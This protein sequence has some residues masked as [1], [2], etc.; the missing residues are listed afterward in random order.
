MDTDYIYKIRTQFRYLT[1]NSTGVV[2]DLYESIAA[3][4]ILAA[5]DLMENNDREV[6]IAIKEYNTQTHRVMNRRNKPRKNMPAYITEKLPRNKQQYIN[7]TELFFLLG[8]PVVWKKEEGDDKAYAAFLRFWRTYRLDTMLRR[9]KRLAGAETEA[10]LVFHLTNAKGQIAVKPF[11]A[12]RSTGYRLRP[13]FDQYGD[14]IALALKYHLRS[15]GRNVAHVDFLTA[16]FS[17]YCSN[18]ESQ[19]KIDT[20]PNPTGKINALYFRQPKAWDG[21]VARLD[22][23]EMLDS[24]VS[25]TNNYFAD[26]KAAATADVV[27]GLAD[28]EMAGN[29]IQLM[30]DKSRFEYINPPSNSITR[31]DEKADLTQSIFHDTFTPDLTY[32]NIKGLGTLS[33]AA[34]HNALTLGYIKRDIRKETYEPMIDRLR[35]VVFAIVKLTDPKAAPLMD[36]LQASFEFQDP[37][38]TPMDNWG[39]IMQLRQA[40]LCSLETAV[41]Q[42]ALAD[43]VDEEIDRILMEQQELEYVR[44][45]AQA[46]QPTQQAQE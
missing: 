4:D 26:P 43:N 16:D 29:M 8:K 9:V 7:E 33:G 31:Q 14:L 3:A 32:E 6:D 19:W 42:I 13:L 30:G 34:M 41:R 25:D 1:L 39:A 44:N 15:K 10:A 23:E 28:P 12:A 35:S 40:G 22:R 27:Q 11:V 20:Y 5:L 17:F 45:E 2:R 38:A 18:E 24:K 37:F 46:V 21:A 36:G